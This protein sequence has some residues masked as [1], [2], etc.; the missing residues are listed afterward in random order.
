MNF[1]AFNKLL[2]LL[3][4]NLRLNERFARLSSGEPVSCE[5]MLLAGGSYHDI[6]ETAKVSR[7]SF[8]RVIWHTI[9]VINS[10]N[11]LEIKLPRQEELNKLREA[12]QMK[13]T[14]GVMNGCIGTLDGYLM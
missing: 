8:Y 12:F 6:L 11:K 7:A 4:P 13:S 3:Q 1:E 14:P 9:N 2:H 5:A 10:C